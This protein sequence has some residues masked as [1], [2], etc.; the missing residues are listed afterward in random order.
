MISPKYGWGGIQVHDIKGV[1]KSEFADPSGGVAGLGP[2]TK[3]ANDTE[4]SKEELQQI[5]RTINLKDF[6]VGGLQYQ[7]NRNVATALTHVAG[8]AVPGGF[9]TKAVVQAGL[10]AL[11]FAGNYD[12]GVQ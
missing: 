3:T 4:L 1:P 7:I 12:L 11:D 8:L 6:Q 9:A 5:E 10:M 2:Y